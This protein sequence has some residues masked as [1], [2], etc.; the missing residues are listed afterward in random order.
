L[1]NDKGGLD[2]R[3]DGWMQQEEAKEKKKE[4]KALILMGT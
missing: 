3:T 4:K 1:N 2:G